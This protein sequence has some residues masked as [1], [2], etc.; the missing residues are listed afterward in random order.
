[1]VLSI[2]FKVETVQTNWLLGQ[3]FWVNQ[4]HGF[5]FAVPRFEKTDAHWFIGGCLK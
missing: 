1:M 4:N 5:V 2:G 3:C